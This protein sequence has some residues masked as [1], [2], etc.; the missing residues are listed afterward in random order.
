MQSPTDREHNHAK[1]LT[2]RNRQVLA[3]LFRD[4]ENDLCVI[5]QT[6][7]AVTDEQFRAVIKTGDDEQAAAFFTGLTD[8]T[9]AVALDQLGMPEEI[10]RLEEALA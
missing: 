9:L 2:H 10:E 6:W 3:Y 7:V 1:L 5:L 4:G 8:E